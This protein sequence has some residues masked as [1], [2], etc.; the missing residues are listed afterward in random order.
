MANGDGLTEGTCVDKLRASTSRP[1]WPT[2]VDDAAVASQS[3]SP[4]LQRFAEMFGGDRVCAVQIGNRPRNPQHAIVTSGGQRQLRQ[5]GTQQSASARLDRRV[6]DAQVVERSA[7]RREGAGYRRPLFGS[8]R[9]RAV[10]SVDEKA[11]IQALNRTQPLLPMRPGQVQRRTHDCKGHGT[12]T[13][14]AALNANTSEVITQFHQ[15]LRSVSS[16]MSRSD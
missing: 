8:A 2:N 1:V 16:G 5:R 3:L 10:L 11:Q 7:A 9:A 14:F 12:T 4:K 6:R 15:R 13:L